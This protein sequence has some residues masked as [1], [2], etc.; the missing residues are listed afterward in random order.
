VPASCCKPDYDAV[1]D[2][3]AAQQ[4]AE[5]YR[6]S[7]VQGSTRRLVELITA[8]GVR[9]ASVLDVGGGVEVIGIELL[10][11]GAA[12]LAGVDA[13]R[14]YVAVATAE[15]AR[16]GLTERATVR[17]GDFVELAD[18]MEPADVVTLDR[19][20]CCYGDWRAL[21]DRSA[22]HARRVFGL[23][24]PNDRW[25]IRA[26]IGVGNLWMRLTRTS[27]RGYVHPERGIDAHI[28]ESGFALRSHHR[29]WVWQTAVYERVTAT[30]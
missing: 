14:A 7:G 19:V 29:G 15:L 10:Q 4:D 1:F 5:R 30:P 26:A 24:Y 21:V 27:Y 28:R 23:V 3:R 18:E 16:R 17:Y 12:L 9:G 13:S 22:R 25:W 2:D 8:R 20:V 11:A 6:R